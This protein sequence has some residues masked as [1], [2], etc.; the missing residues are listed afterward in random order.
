M[1]TEAGASEVEPYHVRI[2]PDPAEIGAVRAS[3]RAIAVDAGFED[4]ANDL[5]LA[6]DELLAN[7]QEHGSPPV[8]VTAWH[9]GRLVIEVRDSGDGINADAIWRSHPPGPYGT[10]GR[11]LW[12]VRQL[13]DVVRIHHEDGVTRV[14]VELSTDPMIG[15]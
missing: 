11:G 6:L 1:A 5:V 3:V 9:D 8:D 2:G 13:C 7:A 15:A 12:I 10:R 4:R 14:R